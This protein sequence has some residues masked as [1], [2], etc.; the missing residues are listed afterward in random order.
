MGVPM[1][2]LDFAPEPAAP[3]ATPVVTS[4]MNCNPS[5]DTRDLSSKFHF[6]LKYW[7]YHTCN[8]LNNYLILCFKYCTEKYKRPIQKKLWPF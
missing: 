6:L 8:V 7:V 3:T 1:T 5:H 4:E 2:Y